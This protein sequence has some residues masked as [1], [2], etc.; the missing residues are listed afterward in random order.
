MKHWRY[1]HLSKIVI[2]KGQKIKKLD[3]I[4]FMGGTGG[5]SSHLHLDCLI[6]EPKNWTEYVIGKSKKWVLEHY[7]DPRNYT[8]KDVPTLYNHLGYGWLEY[9]KYTGGN[10][11]HPGLDING[12]GAGNADLGQPIYSVCDGEVEFVYDGAE[13]N[14]GW[15]KMI[16]IKEEDEPQNLPVLEIKEETIPDNQPEKI[17]SQNANSSVQSDLN[18]II[19]NNK[20]METIKTVREFFKGKKTITIAILMIALGLLQGNNEMVMEGFAFIA[21]RSG[22]K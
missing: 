8:S 12:P 20:P 10:A 22:I 18:N 5:W 21:L 6:Y 13:K 2:V 1:G 15:G 9:A 11:Y 4:G 19:I 3:L 16:I 7:A 17:T 14:S